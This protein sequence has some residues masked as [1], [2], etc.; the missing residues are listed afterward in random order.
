MNLKGLI[1]WDYNGE[2]FEFDLTILINLKIPASSQDTLQQPGCVLLT[3]NMKQG[4]ETY[5]DGH[6]PSLSV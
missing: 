6:T 4:I 1:E 5:L 3:I 2:E